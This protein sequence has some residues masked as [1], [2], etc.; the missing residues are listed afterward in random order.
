MVPNFILLKTLQNHVT[1]IGWNRAKPETKI[2]ENHTESLKM[3]LCLWERRALI[4]TK[5]LNDT[6]KAVKW[7]GHI[8]DLNENSLENFSSKHLFNRKTK[9]AKIVYRWFVGNY[10]I[11]W[12][13]WKSD[14]RPVCWRDSPSHG[15]FIVRISNNKHQ[16][17]E[18]RSMSM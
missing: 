5:R 13:S 6:Y 4:G 2:S 11:R 14:E 3:R 15:W 8:G 17:R 18:W 1:I 12:K 7:W 16:P 10:K 9:I